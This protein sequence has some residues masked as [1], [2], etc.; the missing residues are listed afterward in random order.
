MSTSIRWTQISSSGSRRTSK[1]QLG[2]SDPT[3][4]MVVNGVPWWFR[5]TD[6][7]LAAHPDPAEDVRLREL[8]ALRV[9]RSRVVGYLRR[10]RLRG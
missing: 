5:L 2:F 10:K 1:R 9:K 7:E 8:E 3:G 4:E 6:G